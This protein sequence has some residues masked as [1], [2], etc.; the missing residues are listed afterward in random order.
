MKP[1]PPRARIFAGDEWVISRRTV[2]ERPAARQAGIA[3]SPSLDGDGE[4]LPSDNPAAE[5]PQSQICAD[6]PRP[7]QPRSLDGVREEARFE[8]GDF[9]AVQLERLAKARVAD[10]LAVP[11]AE[12]EQVS[13]RLDPSGEDPVPEDAAHLVLAGTIGF[14]EPVC[15]ELRQFVGHR[16]PL[17]IR[18]VSRFHDMWMRTARTRIPCSSENTR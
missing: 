7:T 17:P 3:G 2:H 4:E 5:G 12:V 13:A 8:M 1:A 18:R 11:G 16:F 10:E 9:E 6:Q 15:V 14:V